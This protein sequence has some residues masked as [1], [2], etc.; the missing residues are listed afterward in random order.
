MITIDKT[1]VSGVLWY[2]SVAEIFSRYVA[3]GAKYK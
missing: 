2:T 1:T 3:Y